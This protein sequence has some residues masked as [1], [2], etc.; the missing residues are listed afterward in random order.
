MSEPQERYVDL[1][2][3][4]RDKDKVPLLRLLIYGNT[5][6]GKTHLLG[7]A[8]YDDRLW[9]MLVLNSRGQPVTFRVFDDWPCVFNM[10]WMGDYNPP[11][12]WIAAGQPPEVLTDYVSKGHWFYSRVQ[13]YFQA[14]PDKY[15]EDP[16]G[17]KFKSIAIDSVTQV[18]RTVMRKVVGYD[19]EGP[20]TIPPGTTRQQWGRVLAGTSNFADLQFA[21]KLPVH[22]FMTA[23]NRNEVMPNLGMVNNYPYLWGQSSTEV[24]S[25]AEVVGRLMLVAE[26]TLQMK[27]KIAEQSG[28]SLDNV[29]N[30]LLTA[31][32]EGY[33]A[34]WQGVKPAPKFVLDPT[35]SKVLD[36]HIA[37]SNR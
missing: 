22:V 1:D 23:L 27:G 28:R 17:W 11:Y 20:G 7:T 9:P 24:P 4:S 6:A 2:A 8:S 29:H 32:G 31:S 14:R 30:V 12:H 21:E 34:K 26:M 25:Y 35:L 33:F 10:D 5:G 19:T 36:I 16:Q 13:E 3:I 18:Q 37:R 15:G